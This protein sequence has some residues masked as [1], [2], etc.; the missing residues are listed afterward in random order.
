MMG[1]DKSLVS[2]FMFF[3]PQKLFLFVPWNDC[4]DMFVSVKEASI[5]SEAL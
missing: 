1:N 2:E 3:D 4:L 5:I